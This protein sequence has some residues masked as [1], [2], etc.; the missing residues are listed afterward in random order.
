MPHSSDEN[1]SFASYQLVRTLRNVA[2]LGR[3]S[4]WQAVP[5]A[6][7]DELKQTLL[8]LGDSVRKFLGDACRV[9]I[10]E[11]IREIWH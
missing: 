11:A 7:T 8:H 6:T 10:E 3:D 9:E 5:I 2:V 4:G 1:K